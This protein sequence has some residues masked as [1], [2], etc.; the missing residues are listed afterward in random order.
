[1]DLMFPTGRNDK[2]N[3]SI[4]SVPQYM[5][6]TVNYLGMNAEEAYAS[7]DGTDEHDKDS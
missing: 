5:Q 1:M 3:F 7:E 4:I 2:S 6:V